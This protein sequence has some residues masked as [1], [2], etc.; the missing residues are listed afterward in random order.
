V[1]VPTKSQN[2]SIEEIE[3][4]LAREN[5]GDGPK[6]LSFYLR[7]RTVLINLIVMSY[8]WASVSFCYYMVSFQIKYLP[9]DIYTNGIAS[10]ISEILAYFCSGLVYRY[11]KIRLSFCVSFAVG[12]VGGLLILF[13]G[14]SH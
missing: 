6:P 12:L 13:L 7:Q 11:L 5:R 9:G 8:M 14:S 2:E 1:K 4:F 3:V 10:S